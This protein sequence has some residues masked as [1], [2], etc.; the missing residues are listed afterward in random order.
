MKFSKKFIAIELNIFL[1]SNT[2]LLY[3]KKYAMIITKKKLDINILTN[4]GK[5]FIFCINIA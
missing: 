5:L 4:S 1:C 3:I 2:N